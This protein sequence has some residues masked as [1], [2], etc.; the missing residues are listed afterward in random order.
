MAKQT[1]LE[2]IN[3]G[4]GRI[5]ERGRGRTYNYDA[6]LYSINVKYR[7]IHSWTTPWQVTLWVANTGYVEF[8]K[9]LQP[10]SIRAALKK[11]RKRVERKTVLLAAAD[12][13]I[14]MEGGF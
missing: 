13:A 6:Q 3:L 5:L 10:R 4:S 1:H 14:A 12:S 7:A 2:T 8:A 9:S 11:A